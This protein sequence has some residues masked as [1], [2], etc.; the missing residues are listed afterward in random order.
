VVALIGDLTLGKAAAGYLIGAG[1]VAVI[2]LIVVL[3]SIRGRIV[4]RWSTLRELLA[5]GL[6]TWLSTSLWNVNER[7]DQ[8]VLSAFFSAATLGLYVVAVT[9]TAVT[10]TIGFGF[11]LVAMPLVAGARSLSERRDIAHTVVGATL[12]AS[13]VITI[14]LLLVEP[15][16]I[17]TLFGDE[18]EGAVDVGRILLVAAVFFGLNRVLESVL[19]G[20]GR[21]LD[22]SIGEGIALICTV[23]GLAVLLPTVGFLGAGITSLL[24]Y[25]A[26]TA[27]LLRRASRALEMPA[28][29][30]LAPQPAALREMLTIA[31]QRA[32]G[33]GAAPR[34]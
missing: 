26:A 2:G 27:F 9:M 24:A 10:T 14:P 31:R 17:R 22:S 19:Q 11:A 32:T 21:P 13:A 4:A 12:L 23:V 30:L 20:A 34:R 15:W 5:Y 3:R 6:K 8:L 25:L 28:R 29:R 1:A 33:G 18:F 16:L 7:A